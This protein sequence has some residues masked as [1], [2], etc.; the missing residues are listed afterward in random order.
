M[1]RSQV[2]AEVPSPSSSGFF[3]KENI[4][5]KN[6]NEALECPKR[7]GYLRR[8]AKRQRVKKGKDSNVINVEAQQSS[9]QEPDS[10]PT[11][12]DVISPADIPVESLPVESP[13][14]SCP[15]S[16]REKISFSREALEGL[17]NL[18]SELEFF[19]GPGEE[20]V[21]NPP[22]S[23]LQAAPEERPS[24]LAEAHSFSLPPSLSG[25]ERLP[26]PALEALPVVPG[27]DTEID[28]S[29]VPVSSEQ[30]FFSRCCYF[31]TL[32]GVA[33]SL[34]FQ[35]L[36]LPYTSRCCYFLTLPGVATSLHFQVLLLPYT[37]RCCYFLTLPG[38]ATSLH[39]QVLLL[40]A[41][42]PSFV[43]GVCHTSSI[44]H[45]ENVCPA[46]ILIVVFPE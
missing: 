43:L 9:N 45:L 27:A 24:Q 14:I 16:P 4:F 31:L 20:T 3:D 35:V 21:F 12:T 41:V 26:D 23:P 39:F 46:K 17:K 11:F 1:K 22:P 34:H 18:T 38:V 19:G 7:R 25:L 8:I 32:P 2:R 36:L 33:T 6:E 10:L 30:A 42:V 15:V 37:S 5:V 13:I 29:S 28:I 44:L 40:L